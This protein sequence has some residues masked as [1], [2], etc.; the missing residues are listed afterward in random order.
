MNKCNKHHLL[1]FKLNNGHYQAVDT[2]CGMRVENTV[3]YCCK[4]HEEQKI[5]PDES[6]KYIVNDGPIMND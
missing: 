5:Q 4:E 1:F 6:A 3:W 2:I